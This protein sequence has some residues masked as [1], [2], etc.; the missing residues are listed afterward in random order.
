MQGDGRMLPHPLEHGVHIQLLVFRAQAFN[1]I[2]TVG[3]VA[4]ITHKMSLFTPGVGGIH[5]TA[6]GAYARF[7][8][9]HIHQRRATPHAAVL[10]FLHIHLRLRRGQGLGR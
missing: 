2:E 8:Y 3:A 1:D 4:R 6:V 7:L 5:L 9:L 10:L